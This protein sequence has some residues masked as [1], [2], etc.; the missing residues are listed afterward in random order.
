M[1]ADKG[2]VLMAKTGNGIVNSLKQKIFSP[3]YLAIMLIL[4][5]VAGNLFNWSDAA[6][7]THLN[8]FNPWLVLLTLVLF[9]LYGYCVWKQGKKS[10]RV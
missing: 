8:A 1:L 6:Y 9:S 3:L 7:G 4:V 5:I 10:K 2:S